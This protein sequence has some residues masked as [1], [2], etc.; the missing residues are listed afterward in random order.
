MAVARNG[1]QEG[2]N[3]VS[4]VARAYNGGGSPWS[5]AQAAKAPF[6]ALH[7]Q[8]RWQVCWLTLLP[9]VFEQ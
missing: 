3:M 5:G 6:S 8:Q 4:A 1:K 2:R 7:N 9:D